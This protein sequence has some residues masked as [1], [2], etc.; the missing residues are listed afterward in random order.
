MAL[1]FAEIA[2]WSAGE[3]VAAATSWTTPASYNPTTDRVRF[4][5]AGWTDTVGSY[6]TPTLTGGGLTWVLVA[7]A[8]SHSV[9]GHPHLCVFRS[10]GVG[11][12]GALTFTPSN[13]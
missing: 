9:F 8:I 5:A 10:K 7:A 12:N 2:N 3:N 13:G 1:S 11:S 4:V 6:T